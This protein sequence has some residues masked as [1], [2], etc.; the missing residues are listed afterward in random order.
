MGQAGWGLIL[1]ALSGAMYWR[2][3]F[4]TVRAVLVALGILMIGFSNTVVHI[5]GHVMDLL[6]AVAG[7]TLGKWLGVG[8][9]AVVG[10]GFIV[11]VFL[12]FHDWLPKN[13][14]KKSTYWISIAVALIVVSAATP[15]AAVN[16]MP[17]SFRQGVNTSF[18]G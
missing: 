13:S 17:A 4:A 5:V 1:V 6:T 12:M 3:R 11:L 15:F 2:N 7:V 16:G 10:A 9:G 8:A 14:A 18:Q